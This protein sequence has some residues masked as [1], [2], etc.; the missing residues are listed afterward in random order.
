MFEKL[1]DTIEELGLGP[2][3]AVDDLKTRFVRL[4]RR[5]LRW[6]DHSYTLINRQIGI[7]LDPDHR[8]TLLMRTWGKIGGERSRDIRCYVCNRVVATARGRHFETV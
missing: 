3:V 2:G 1:S 5:Y 4:C 7:H 8:G 6:C